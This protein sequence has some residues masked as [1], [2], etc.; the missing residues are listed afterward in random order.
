MA[1]IK[2]YIPFENKRPRIHELAGLRLV[3]DD[4][5][6]KLHLRSHLALRIMGHHDLHLNWAADKELRLSYYNQDSLSF[7]ISS[8]DGIPL[9]GKVL[10][11]GMYLRSS[12]D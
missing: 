7:T 8:Y 10:Q 12:P 4:V 5:V 2:F 1:H 11:T 9:S 3:D 6:W